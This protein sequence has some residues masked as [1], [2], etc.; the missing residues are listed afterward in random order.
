MKTILSY[1][2]A[3]ALLGT[4]Y[5]A[6]AEQPAQP[7]NFVI[8]PPDDMDYGDLGQTGAIGCTTPKV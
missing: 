2:A 5:T 8:I 3:L 4:S 6:R 1:S 7:V